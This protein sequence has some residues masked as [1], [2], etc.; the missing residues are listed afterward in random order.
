MDGVA[1]CLTFRRA[2]GES[3]GQALVQDVNGFLRAN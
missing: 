2:I 3:A 1:S